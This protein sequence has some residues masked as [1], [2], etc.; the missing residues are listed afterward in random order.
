MKWKICFIVGRHDL[1]NDRHVIVLVIFSINFAFKSNFQLS[2]KVVLLVWFK[3]MH[4]IW[5]SLKHTIRGMTI[6]WSTTRSLVRLLD[7]RILHRPKFVKNQNANKK[8]RLQH[9]SYIIT[10]SKSTRDVI[11][12]LNLNMI[13]GQKHIHHPTRKTFMVIVENLIEKA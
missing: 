9:C 4:I 3:S 1:S 7:F 12:P 5:K 11:E 2:F 6:F 10:N 13:R 8:M